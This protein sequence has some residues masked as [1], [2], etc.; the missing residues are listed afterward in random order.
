MYDLEYRYC[1]SDGATTMRER[2]KLHG[3]NIA[4]YLPFAALLIGLLIMAISKPIVIQSTPPL[5]MPQVFAGEYSFDHHNWHPLESAADLSALDGDLYLRGHF[6][7]PVY[8]D[9][10]L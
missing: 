6:E 7:T 2:K 5:P 9:S 10:R 8:A 3:R 1:N 4:L